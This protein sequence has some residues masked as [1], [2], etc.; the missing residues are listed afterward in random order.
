MFRLTLKK[1]AKPSKTGGKEGPS[2]IIT[3]YISPL[4]SIIGLD[5]Y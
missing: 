5:K 2:D 1:T 3:T 4:Q